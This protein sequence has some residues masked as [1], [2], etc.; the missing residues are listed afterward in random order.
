MEVYRLARK[1][2][3]GELSGKGSALYGARWNSVG[4]EL[5]YTAQ[6]R[7]LAM[8]EIVVH[9][10]LATLPHD[11]LMMTISIPD[12]IDMIIVRE[13]DLPTGWNDFPYRTSSQDVG[14]DFARSNKTCL[15][16]VPS[17][18]VQG[19]HNILI[20]PKHKDFSGIK[21]VKTVEFPFDKRIF[22]L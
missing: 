18:V 2:F 7:A 13:E 19:E 15:L 9:L 20:N 10:T 5:V 14:D 3:A 6:N 1:Q 8:A 12:D 21:I 4:I 22:K 16:Q 11:F 17:A